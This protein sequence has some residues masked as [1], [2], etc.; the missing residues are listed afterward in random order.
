MGWGSYSRL[1]EQRDVIQFMYYV[2]LVGMT[3]EKCIRTGLGNI[4]NLLLFY[5]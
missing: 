2:G 3:E 1:R 5:V 4:K